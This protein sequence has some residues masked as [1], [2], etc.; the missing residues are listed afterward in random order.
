VRGQI[1]DLL[2]ACNAEVLREN[3]DVRKQVKQKVDG[4]LSAMNW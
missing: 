4:I 3:A 1:N 2:G